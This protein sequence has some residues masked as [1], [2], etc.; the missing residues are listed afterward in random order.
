MVVAGIRRALLRLA[1][2]VRRGEYE[3]RLNEEIG[4]HLDMHAA[5]NER[6]GMSPEDAR[7]AALIRFGGRDRW[8]EATRDQYRSRPLEDFALDIRYAL[9]TLGKSPTFTLTA[10]ATLALGIGANT[11]IFSAVDGVLFKPL[12]FRQPETIVTLWQR[13]AKTPSVLTDV[14]PGTFLDWQTRS[15][16]FAQLAAAEPYSVNLDGAEGPENVRNWNVTDGFF[17]VLGVRPYLGRL[18]EAADFQPG[19]SRVVV[20]SYDGWRRRY[21]GD[22]TVVGRTIRV[23]R[24]PATIVGVLPPHVSVPDGREMWMPKIL[25]ET[26]RETRGSAYYKVIGRLAPNIGVAAANAEMATIAAGLG[27]EYP[28]TNAGVGAAV[29][30]ITE[31]VVGPVRPALLMLLGAV[32][33]VLLIA[34]ANVAGLLLA[35][36]TRRGRE[37]AIRAALGAGRWRVARQLLAES[38]V[39]AMLSVVAGIAL[40]H[41]C[42]GVIRAL[43]PS[44]LPRVGEMEVDA[45]ALLF[46]AVA[47]AATT[48]LSGLVPSLRGAR[49]DLQD[50]LRAGRSFT[51]GVRAGARRAL[52]IGEVAIAVVL[53]VGAGL[54]ARS[55]VTL[56]RV[57]RGYRSDHVLA[58]S[59]FIWQW[60]ETPADRAAFVEQ[61]VD[62]LTVLPGVIA[63]GATSALPVPE[64]IGPSQGRL[65][66][67][68][69]PL[70]SGEEIGVHVS[71]VTPG[72]FAALRIPLRAGRLFERSDEASRLDVAVVNETMAHRYWPNES[73]IGKRIFLRF[74]R[75]GAD[76]IERE[77]VGVVGDVRQE[78]LEQ[79]SKSAVF[80][81][82]AQY[83]TGSMSLVLR[84]TGDPAAA[85]PALRST[86][87]TLNGELPITSGATLDEM[88][89]E[90]LKPRRFTLLLLASFSG[91]ALLLAI[92]GVY[93]LIA[94]SAAERTREI[95]V[96]IALGARSGDVLGLVVRQGLAPVVLGT[97]IGM[98]AAFGFSQVL[99]DMLFSIAPIDGITFALVPGLVLLTATLACGLPAWRATRVDPLIAL[100]GE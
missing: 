83:P 99:R 66:I 35:R 12:P 51:T 29:V 6:L 76:P 87:A 16:S 43:S 18:F 24:A 40:A 20:L 90:T 37:L 71:V 77:I 69:R 67:E 44:T 65:T 93:G 56:L 78:G 17:A 46:A 92:V 39:L 32:G 15:R 13:D 31:H 59:V 8:T 23:E 62:R 85:L 100:R 36:T 97:A 80:I 5:R 7:R 74:G 33:L 41:W 47:G 57:E 50:E 2:F 42:V 84:T 61:V 21:G 1:G 52:V 88:L 94:Q 95:G 3:E 22:R 98:G 68:G 63:A 27:R 81:P 14:A 11:A 58:A 19:Q 89:A 70:A 64:R 38:L 34:C 82:H 54:L 73:P 86:L 96:R 91:A 72:L 79:P 28:H 4:F 53:L 48:L 9:R 10:V 60:N 26:E 75:F 49:A 45:R 30:P 55:F 25:D